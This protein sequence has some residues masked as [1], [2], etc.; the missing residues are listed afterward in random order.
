MTDAPI[1]IQ[2]EKLSKVYG[3]FHALKDVTFSIPRGQVAAFL[4]ALVDAQPLPL[5]HG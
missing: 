1:M 4:G 2:A 3:S 5:G